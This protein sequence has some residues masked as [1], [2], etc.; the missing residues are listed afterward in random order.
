MRV[1]RFPKN[2]GIVGFF[3]DFPTEEN[4]VAKVYTSKVGS[5]EPL[6]GRRV[7][8]IGYGSQGHA[9]AQNLRDSGVRVAIGRRPGSDNHRLAHTRGVGGLRAGAFE[10]TFKDETETDLFGEQVVLCGGR[11]VNAGTRLEMKKILKEIQSGKFAREFRRE[12]TSGGKRFRAMEAE[13][14][15]NGFVAGGGGGDPPR[16]SRRGAVPHVRGQRGHATGAP[17]RAIRRDPMRQTLR[18]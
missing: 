5:L 18:R 8:I 11:I 7:A 6:K 4:A 15:N 3:K 16:L 9:Q 14:N 1:A 12:P 2:S 13:E 10:T 17:S